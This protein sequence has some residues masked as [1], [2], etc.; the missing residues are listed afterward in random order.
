MNKPLP[1]VLPKDHRP[2]PLL[3]LLFVGSGC[4][5]LIYEIVWLQLL[6]LLIGSTAV[7]MGVLL[8]I[9]MGGMCLGSLLQPWLIKRRYHPLKVYA[10]LEFGIAICGLL[11]LWCMPLIEM[12]YSTMASGSTGV[13]QRAI[14]AALCL[15][16]PTMMMG[17]TL[18]AI[19]RWVE[20]SPGGVSWLGFFYGSN[21]A[22]A[23]LGCLL[24]GFYLLRVF[25]MGIATYCAALINFFVAGIGWWLAL[26]SVKAKRA[27]R[28][29]AKKRGED[30]EAIDRFDS[31]GGIGSQ[32]PP[33]STSSKAILWSIIGLSGASALGCEVIWTRLLSLLMGGTVY[34]FSIILAVFLFGLGVGSSIGS[35]L[36]RVS[37][38]PMRNLIWCQS[39]SLLAVCWTS[40]MIARSLPH[41]PIDPTAGGEIWFTFQFDIARCMFVILPA[42]VLW[43]ASFPLTLAVIAGNGVSTRKRDASR[44]VGNT[45]A[46]NTLGAIIGALTFSILI[47]PTSG[48]LVA[49]Y[50]ILATILCSILLSLFLFVRTPASGRRPNPV[51]L[52]F[53]AV[54]F[55][56]ACGTSITEVPW[57]V[58]AYGRFAAKNERFLAPEVIAPQFVPGEAKPG[59]PTEFCLMTGEGINV[60]VAVTQNND[61]IRKFHGGGKVQASSNP[62]DMRL[63]RMLG[64]LPALIHENPEDV[65]VVACGAGVTAGSFL[66]HPE[67]KSLTICD[68]EPL[69]PTQ[70]TPYFAEVNHNVVGKENSNRV[71]LHFD[72]GRHYV[73]T[74]D[75]K[76][77]I[78]T[79]DPIDPW[80]KGCATLNTVEYYQM[81]RERLKPGGIMALWMPL[82]ESDPQTLKSV[83]T[84]F[85]EV[86]P[87]GILWT[88]DYS[89]EGYDAV[90]FG[91]VGGT[92]I[93]L[94]EINK[95]FLRPDHQ[96]VR[97]SLKEVGFEDVEELLATYAGNAPYMRSWMKGAQVNT[98]INLRLQYL[99][100]LSLNSY[101]G[102][103]LLDGILKHYE[104]PLEVFQGSPFLQRK[105]KDYLRNAGRIDS[106]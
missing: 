11:I 91:Q 39:L 3:L 37:P 93:N 27:Q 26:R 32:L 49:Q 95:R 2:L 102:G 17:A 56:F 62:E 94:D 38:N 78:I 14:V 34:T 31:P 43:G 105:L 33:A 86:F 47:I 96:R 5:A 9:F 97:D 84:T 58:I 24:A 22:G 92:Q 8:G 7:S 100:G 85:F 64:H 99:A 79:S 90:L 106:E 59:Q 57:G 4:A 46:A 23:V 18:P 82:Y 83:I 30:P 19:S 15:L 81:C 87:Q 60:S 55:T 75:K 74:T 45:Y 42:T 51:L 69:V 16:P 73:R 104:F 21:I 28:L 35:L 61:G 67:V 12:L 52:A 71:K 6:Q 89:G 98:D 70:V 29:E 25:D 65:L 20:A 103:R 72:D 63:Q 77:D 36:A 54:F 53:F 80:V 50:V 88:N 48:T 66:P 76:F 40:N 44:M 101:Q 1:V 13:A 68:I 10:A 41:W